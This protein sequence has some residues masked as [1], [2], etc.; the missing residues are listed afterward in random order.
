MTS[1]QVDPM[2][3]QGLSEI[4]DRFDHV[5][6]DQWGVLHH[7]EAVPARPKPASRA[8]FAAARLPELESTSTRLPARRSAAGAL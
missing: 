5:L 4:A 8:A 6:L 3:I 2:L 1:P 7:G